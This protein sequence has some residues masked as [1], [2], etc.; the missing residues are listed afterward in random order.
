MSYAFFFSLCTMDIGEGGNLDMGY[1][2]G[3]SLADIL[4]MIHI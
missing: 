4:M 2:I 3:I 1:G